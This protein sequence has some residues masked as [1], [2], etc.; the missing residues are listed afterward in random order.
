MI[1]PSRVSGTADHVQ[2]L[3]DLF[4]LI[5]FFFFFFFYSY[6]PLILLFFLFS[7]FLFFFFFSPLLLL[8]HLLN[9]RKGTCNGCFCHLILNR[10]CLPP[11]GLWC[12]E[13]NQLHHVSSGTFL[14]LQMISGHR[15]SLRCVRQLCADSGDAAQKWR[16]TAKGGVYS[17]L[18]KSAAL[19]YDAEGNLMAWNR[20]EKVATG[21][22]HS[23]M[24]KVFVDEDE[25]EV[26]TQDEWI[27][28]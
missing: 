6:L 12:Y 25:V 7:F 23:F 14:T 1:T 15:A 19:A 10:I 24:F 2:S 13:A 17:E 21:Q 3:D 20:K 8:K 26:K 22:H 18:E 4:F 5:F 27:G 11:A 16:L 9:H 28:G